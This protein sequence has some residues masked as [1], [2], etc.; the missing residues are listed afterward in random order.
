MTLLSGWPVV[1][2]RC[3]WCA[4]PLI[5]FEF[6]EG[7]S[8]AR[9]AVPGYHNGHCR[10]MARLSKTRRQTNR[11]EAKKQEQTNLLLED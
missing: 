6:V 8:G 10:E 1:Q 11:Q 9:R 2:G 3:R 5:Y 7:S 4:G